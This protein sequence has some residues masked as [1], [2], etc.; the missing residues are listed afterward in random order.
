SHWRFWRRRLNVRN[1]SSCRVATVTSPMQAPTSRRCKRGDEP[2]S[3]RTDQNTDQNYARR[4][5]SIFLKW[6][7]RARE[8]QAAKAVQHASAI[9]AASMPK[10]PT[11]TMLS[12]LV[13]SKA[14]ERRSHFYVRST[15]R[16]SPAAAWEPSLLPPDVG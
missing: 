11:L 6:E 8:T 4:R 5:G 13:V 2:Q 16:Q 10:S 15:Q 1:R 9:L 12:L 7:K 3:A 14:T